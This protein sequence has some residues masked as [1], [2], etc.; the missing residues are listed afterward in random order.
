[1]PTSMMTHSPAQATRFARAGALFAA[2]AMTSL[3]AAGIDHTSSA[4][5][6]QGLSER[7]AIAVASNCPAPDAAHG[8]GLVL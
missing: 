2:L 8:I 3:I 7:T 5:R 4:L 6:Q 1:M